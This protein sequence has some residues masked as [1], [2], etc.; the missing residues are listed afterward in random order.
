MTTLNV[1]SIK[2]LLFVQESGAMQDNEVLYLER[3]EDKAQTAR[4]ILSLLTRNDSTKNYL[5]EI[6]YNFNYGPKENGRMYKDESDP[7]SPTLVIKTNRLDVI[8][9][10]KIIYNIIDPTYR[11]GRIV[12]TLN[13]ISHQVSV[14]KMLESLPMKTYMVATKIK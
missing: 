5:F 8:T 10:N 7:M 1:L 3:S 4:E 12:V 9:F 11:V 13:G 14:M 6:D 2:E